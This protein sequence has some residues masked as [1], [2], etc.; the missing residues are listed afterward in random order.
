MEVRQRETETVACIESTKVWRWESR[1]CLLILNISLI[2]F[3]SEGREEYHVDFYMW[4]IPG[5]GE[6]LGE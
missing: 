3:L 1:M 4:L 5:N 2:F 6:I